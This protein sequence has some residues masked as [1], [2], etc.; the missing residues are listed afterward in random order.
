MNNIYYVVRLIGLLEGQLGE[1]YLKADNVGLTTNIEDAKWFRSWYQ[2]ELHCGDY[3]YR[4]N[5]SE[6]HPTIIQVTI[7]LEDIGYDDI[8]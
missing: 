8:D 5:N 7:I 3:L 1:Y 6:L 2:A 4:N